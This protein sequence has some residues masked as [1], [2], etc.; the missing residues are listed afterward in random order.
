MTWDPE[1]APQGAP[2]ALC[3]VALGRW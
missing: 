1:N 2:L 3:T